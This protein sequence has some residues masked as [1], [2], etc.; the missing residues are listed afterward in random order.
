MYEIVFYHY[1][2][3]K[4]EIENY[5]DKLSVKAKTN[6]SDRIN[7]TKTLTYLSAL[8]K[9]GTRLGYPMVKHIE[10][11]IWELRPLKNRIFFFCWKDNKIILLH[12]F[13]KKS[14]KTPKKELEIAR[15]NLKDF[16]KR[17]EK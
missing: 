2:N 6:K 17:S 13:V 12:H 5:L 4:S 7:Y 3:G 16:I 14:Q 1:P 9:Y 10:N 8:S 15:K 11:K